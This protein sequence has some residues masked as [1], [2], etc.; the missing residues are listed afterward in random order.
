MG[1]TTTVV[2]ELPTWVW[3]TF[4]VCF[5]LSALADLLLALLKHFVYRERKKLESENH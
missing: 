5:L 2:F 1:E 3:L 4:C